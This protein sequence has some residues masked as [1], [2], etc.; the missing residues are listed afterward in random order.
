MNLLGKIFVVLIFVMSLMFMTMAL[1]VYATHRNWKQEVARTAAEAQQTGQP[2]GW[3]ARYEQLVAQNQK[4][5][6]DH[7]ALQKEVVAERTAKAEALAKLQTELSER[8]QE[9]A[10]A[11]DQLTQRGDQLAHAVATLR[12]QEE[13]VN[14]A[15]TQ[16]QKLTEDIKTQIAMVDDLFKKSLQL[17][18]QLMQAN[19][20][21]PDLRERN[22]QLAQMLANA[23]LLLSQVGMT[24]EDPLDLRPPP[25]D[26]NVEDV[27]RD[28]V[29]I[30]AGSHDGI[31]VGHVLDVIRD[32]R[33]VGKI[34]IT[35]VEKDRAIGRVMSEHSVQQIKRGD[36]ATSKL[37]RLARQG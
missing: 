8:R 11:Q 6:A 2:V 35:N 25:L 17:A 15:T 27:G 30:A 3:K 9:L 28:G 21:L 23:R 22:D 36:T 19:T 26:A 10:A 37:S 34:Q 1:M 31:R 20:E 5:S 13:N 29:E 16:V 14:V 18:N 24:L 33:F 12:T 32:S 7:L 4:L